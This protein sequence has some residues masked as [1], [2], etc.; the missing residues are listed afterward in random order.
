MGCGRVYFTGSVR[1][2]VLTEETFWELSHEYYDG[3]TLEYDDKGKGPR[4]GASLALSTLTFT[5]LSHFRFGLG[6]AKD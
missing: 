5:S 4:T 2:R 3:L 6:D 1:D